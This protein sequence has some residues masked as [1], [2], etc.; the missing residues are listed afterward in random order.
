MF[1]FALILATVAVDAVVLRH[2]GGPDQKTTSPGGPD[3]NK[4]SPGGPEKDTQL[5][6]QMNGMEGA[7]DD[8]IKKA[9]EH[10]KLK[11]GDLTKAMCEELEVEFEGLN[12]G[13]NAVYDNM[14][15]A[16]GNEDPAQA[17]SEKLH[18]LSNKVYDIHLLPVVDKCYNLEEP[19]TKKKMEKEI[20]EITGHSKAA[21]TEAKAAVAAAAA[22][23]NY[24]ASSTSTT[25]C[26][27]VACDGTA[28]TPKVDSPDT[29]KVDSGDTTVPGA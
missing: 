11:K 1:N 18:Q 12:E 3:Q 28:D 21:G 29:P 26:Q 25:A 16:Y 20:A 4:T 19:A 10:D 2:T 8:L 9:G 5:L 22:G 24:T 15:D 14:H 27:G 17:V 23:D 7:V 6:E 13:L